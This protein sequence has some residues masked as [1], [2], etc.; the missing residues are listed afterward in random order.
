MYSQNILRILSNLHKQQINIQGKNI[1]YAI[2][3]C[4]NRI[5][6]T[7]PIRNFH[8]RTKTLSAQNIDK[9]TEKRDPTDQYTHFGY[10]RVKEG[11]K[12]N[13]GKIFLILSLR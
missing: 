11:D 10:E 13:R 1:Q 9:L 3:Y 8:S 2:P 4:R 7:Q 12:V 5:L 6:P